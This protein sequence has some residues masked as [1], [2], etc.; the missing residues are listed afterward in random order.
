M[1]MRSGR[2]PVS[3]V[4][5]LLVLATIAGRAVA[6]VKSPVRMP[7][8]QAATVGGTELPAGSY[9]ISWTKDGSDVKVTFTRG[10]K[11]VAEAAGKLVAREKPS[12]FGGIV[13]RRDGSGKDVVA[14]I[15]FESSKEVIV[16][17]GS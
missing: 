6:D 7:L 3:A 5:V 11:V 12:S 1:I 13:T 10:K 17:Q 16:L 8:L 4:A 15:L 14:E 9:A 2:L